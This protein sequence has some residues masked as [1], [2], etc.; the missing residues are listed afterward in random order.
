[1]EREH[2]RGSSRV[3]DTKL[4][5]TRGKVALYITLSY[6]QGVKPII[7]LI[8][9]NIKVIKSGLAQTRLSMTF[10]N[11][12]TIPWKLGPDIFKQMHSILYKIVRRIKSITLLE[13]LKYFPILSSLSRPL[14]R[15]MAPKAAFRS[16]YKSP[17][18]FILMGHARFGILDCKCQSS[19]KVQI[20]TVASR[21]IQYD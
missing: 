15:R 6:C 21:N 14:A 16:D 9:F 19:Q 8:K 5:E 12:I 3:C 1:M 18:F 13:Q 11:T 2:V 20:G 10:Q 4:I 7:K 17:I